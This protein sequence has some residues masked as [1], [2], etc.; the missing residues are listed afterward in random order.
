MF[1]KWNIDSSYVSQSVS[2]LLAGA[3]LSLTAMLHL[4]WIAASLELTVIFY[5]LSFF[6]I[7]IIFFYRFNIFLFSWK[8]IRRCLISIFRRRICL[9][10]MWLHYFTYCIGKFW[11]ILRR[12]ALLFLSLFLLNPHKMSLLKVLLFQKCFPGILQN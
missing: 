2:Q 12:I 7:S 11:K 4:I 9:A 8:L 1:R 5:L 3:A 10:Y 6:L